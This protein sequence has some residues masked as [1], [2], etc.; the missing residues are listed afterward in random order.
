[1]QDGTAFLTG[2]RTKCNRMNRNG[3][4]DRSLKI[5]LYVHQ[6]YPRHYFGTEQYTRT[7]ARGFEA[8]GHVPVVVTN[9]PAGDE[10]QTELVETF[11]F[12]GIQVFRIDQNKIPEDS[13]KEFRAALHRS[14]LQQIS[15]DIVHVCHLLGHST[16]LLEVAEELSL[17]TFATFT[18][19]HLLCP[20]A[21]LATAD[22]DI[23]D[24][25]NASRSNCI[26][27][28]IADR[29]QYERSSLFWQLLA[30]AGHRRQAAEGAIRFRRWLP[31]TL[32]ME[33]D[34]EI[35]RLA[36]MRAAAERFRTVIA[37]TESLRRIFLQHGFNSNIQL[38]RFGIDIDRRPKPAAANTPLRL[39]YIGQIAPHKALHVLVAAL[40]QLGSREIE[41]QIWGSEQQRP[42]YSAALRE[43]AQNISIQ[44]CGTFEIERMAEILGQIDLL[45][46]PSDWIENSPL[47]M[48]QALA[49]H[50][51]VIVSDVDGLTELINPAVNGFVFRRGSSEDLARTISLFTSDPH[52]ASRM[53]EQTAYQRTESDMVADT[54]KVY[55]QGIPAARA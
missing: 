45:V 33:V 31:S 28:G 39:G 27:C 54:L 12:D 37:P 18:D 49:T 11:E 6:Y 44:F 9:I 3:I 48:L 40:N 51:P 10:A 19:F 42:D 20:R 16:A 46:I 15:P 53:S 7:L 2:C 4:P 47:T 25:P 30:F 41:L 21:T 17:P 52:L 29:A 38:V 36:V 5:A 14:V 32:R 55:L 8:L 13:P 23:C 50:T 34:A 1:M 35:G 43:L 26:N 24:G 22:G